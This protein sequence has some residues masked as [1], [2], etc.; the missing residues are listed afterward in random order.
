MSTIGRLVTSKY[1]TVALANLENASFQS[2]LYSKEP[3]AN[4][5]SYVQA[6]SNTAGG[7]RRLLIVALFYAMYRKYM[8]SY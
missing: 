6:R 7:I 3:P 4:T 1:L 5:K 8:K 2:S